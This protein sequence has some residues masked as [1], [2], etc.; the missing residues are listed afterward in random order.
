VTAWREADGTV[1]LLIPSMENYRMRGPDL[2]HL[3]MDPAK[4]YSSAASGHQIAEAEHDY[5]HWLMGPYS[6]DGVHFVTLAHS[7]W[8]ACLLNGDCAQPT[9]TTTDAGANSW[10]NT[11][12]SLAS[13]DGGA[14]WQLNTVGGNHVVA[15]TAYHWTGSTALAQRA[16][17]QAM[18]HSGLFGPTRLVQAGAWWYAVAYSIHRDFTPIDLANGNA[19]APIDKFGYVLMRTSDPGNPN[20]WQAWNGGAVFNDISSQQFLPFLPQSNGAALDV[21]T[22]QLVY[23]TVAQCYILFFTRYGQP[24][25]VYYTTT[26]SLAAPAWSEATAIVGSAQFVSDAAGQVAGFNNENYVSII[27]PKAAGFNFDSTSGSPMLFYNTSPAAYGG[28]NQARD[29]YRVQLT[30]NYGP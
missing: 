5:D 17:L 2:L 15:D 22:P 25:S 30:V 4:I 13:A 29:V 11:L 16:Y 21:A 1:N 26:K 10:A 18:N 24:T 19:E 20:G 28:D 9:S 12:N 3:S 7:E 6:T 27:D 8:Y 23:D 14:T